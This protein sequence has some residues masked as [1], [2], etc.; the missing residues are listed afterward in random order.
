LTQTSTKRRHI[1]IASIVIAVIL[2]AAIGATIVY[3]QLTATRIPIGSVA[4]SGRAGS[5][6]LIQPW[7]SSLIRIQFV[8]RQT[9][10][11]ISFDFHFP[12]PPPANPF[13]NYSVILMN[14]H[15]YSVTIIYYYAP[16][17]T[18]PATLWDIGADYIGDFTV[19]APAG[20]TALS[21]SFG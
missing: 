6:A 16:S 14:N 15:T 1:I 11:N 19:N 5:A 7:S 17:S 3:N 8:E 20:E 10:A 18:A 4:V 9:G 13:G 21:Q 12:H 2:V